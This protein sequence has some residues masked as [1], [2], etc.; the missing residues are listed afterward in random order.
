MLGI[1][2][3]YVRRLCR[4]G[5][6][7]RV[8]IGKIWY[9]LHN[10]NEIKSKF[11]TKAPDFEQVDKWKTRRSIKIRVYREFK[12][13]LEK[14]RYDYFKEQSLEMYEGSVSRSFD[15]EHLFTTRMHWEQYLREKLIKRY[16]YDVLSKFPKYAD[17]REFKARRAPDK[18]ARGKIKA[19]IAKHRKFRTKTFKTRRF[20]EFP[21]TGT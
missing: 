19:I 12:N 15:P 1:S 5:V 21:S 11:W 4:K 17:I 6:F 13:Y 16:K 3:S 7:K 20:Y 14:I 2:D 18:T 9:L 10:K 8:K